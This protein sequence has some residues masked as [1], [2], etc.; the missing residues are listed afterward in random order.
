LLKSED[1][2]SKNKMAWKPKVP[3]EAGRFTAWCKRAGFDSPS[4]S[5]VRKA[6]ATAK[7]TGNKSLRGMAMFALRAKKGW[8][9]KGLQ[10]TV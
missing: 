7:K 8:T 1:F 5:C 9:K 4:I 10:K 2:V 6:L 3:I